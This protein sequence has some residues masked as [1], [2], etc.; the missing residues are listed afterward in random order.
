MF[1]CICMRDNATLNT[2]THTHMNNR[3]RMKDSQEYI[4]QEIW[5]KLTVYG[6]R[7]LTFFLCIDV[8]LVLGFDISWD[9]NFYLHVHQ[10]L[11]SEMNNL[12]MS[13]NC[14]ERESNVNPPDNSL[15]KLYWKLLFF[16]FPTPTNMLININWYIFL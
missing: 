4:S 6:V 3:E 16:S 11:L 13:Q 1:W 10:C 14:A 5:W 2:H 12:Y 9:C 7:F 8:C 15:S